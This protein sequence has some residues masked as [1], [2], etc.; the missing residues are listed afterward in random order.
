M[1]A[2]P[3]VHASPNRAG[4]RRAC[5]KATCDW[6]QTSHLQLLW[7]LLHQWARKLRDLISRASSLKLIRKA[8]KL[9]SRNNQLHYSLMKDTKRH[10]KSV[11][12]RLKIYAKS[13]SR[14]LPKR[15]LGKKQRSPNGSYTRQAKRWISMT[16]IARIRKEWKRCKERGMR[17]KR[18]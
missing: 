16:S 9:P 10:L 15:R 5:C 13:V 11:V 12:K 18:I 4:W 2:L 17:S 3:K 6:V 1:S 7:S 14:S 8:L